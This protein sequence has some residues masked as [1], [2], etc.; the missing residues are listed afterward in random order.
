MASAAAHFSELASTALLSW[1]VFCRIQQLVWQTE[2]YDWPGVVDRVC[3]L[4]LEAQSVRKGLGP[5]SAKQV[6]HI[7][8]LVVIRE[9][10]NY[11]VQA[12]LLWWFSER[13]TT[14]S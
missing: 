3:D 12:L 5:T 14:P 4:K 10:K 2:C 8:R 1:Q 6:V 9:W 7:S 13:L 11:R